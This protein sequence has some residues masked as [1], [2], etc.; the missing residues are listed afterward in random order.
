MKNT[1][2]NKDKNRKQAALYINQ[3]SYLSRMLCVLRAIYKIH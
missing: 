3:N 2:I 1:H